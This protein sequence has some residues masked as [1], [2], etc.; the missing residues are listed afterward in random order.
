MRGLK[1]YGSD[2]SLSALFWD[3]LCHEHDGLSHAVYHE[4]AHTVVAVQLGI[5]FVDISVK[6]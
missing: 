6:Q 3:S 2:M 1:D 5:A 4:A